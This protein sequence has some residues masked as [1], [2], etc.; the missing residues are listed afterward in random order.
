MLNQL[1]RLFRSER[2]LFRALYLSILTLN[3]VLAIIYLF[4]LRIPSISNFYI[5]DH[6]AILIGLGLLVALWILLEFTIL[7]ND[8]WVAHLYNDPGTL[9]YD[10]G[11]TVVGLVT[12]IVALIPG[13]VN[14]PLAFIAGLTC[15]AGLLS[16]FQVRSRYTLEDIQALD[17]NPAKPPP[18]AGEPGSAPDNVTPQPSSSDASQPDKTQTPP[19]ETP[20]TMSP[21]SSDT[22]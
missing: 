7:P 5:P 1:N 16:A 19:G 12:L 8:S 4:K 17:A 9:V 18:P 21:G 13:P 3:P 14:V 10:V 22:T 15:L 20:L 2:S 11:L 6:F